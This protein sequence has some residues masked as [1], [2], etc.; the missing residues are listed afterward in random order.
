[1]AGYQVRGG[2]HSPYL[3]HND[4]VVSPGTRQARF[5]SLRDGLR[6][7]LTEPVRLVRD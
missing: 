3:P 4:G 2:L 6:P 7:H 1:M 5:A